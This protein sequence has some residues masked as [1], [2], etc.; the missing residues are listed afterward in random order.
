MRKDINKKM[1]KKDN[2]DCRNKSIN[3]ENCNIVDDEKCK[4]GKSD[5][6]NYGHKGRSMLEMLGV[7][8]VVGILSAGAVA[9]YQ[10]AMAKKRLNS[11][12]SQITQI[13]SNVRTTLYNSN[14]SRD[15]RGGAG[16]PYA[17]FGRSRRDARSGM[18]MAKALNIIPSE[19]LVTI[20]SA[21]NSFVNCSINLVTDMPTR[22][23]LYS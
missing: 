10:K 20:V 15:R 3:D 23:P 17:I 16:K 22:C 14:I 8:A 6:Q 9:G 1:S 7:L 18:D 12:V 5:E 19:L 11:T 21:S 4:S 13:I 2:L